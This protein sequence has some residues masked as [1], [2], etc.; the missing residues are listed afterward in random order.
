MARFWLACPPEE[1]GR[2]ARTPHTPKAPDVN[3]RTIP[4][5]HRTLPCRRMFLRPG[6]A[7]VT[8]A[9]C[10]LSGTAWASAPETDSALS[11]SASIDPAEQLAQASPGVVPRQ[12]PAAVEEEDEAPPAAQPARTAPRER[13]GPRVLS[14]ED[15]APDV[16]EIPGNFVEPFDAASPPRGV[17]VNIDFNQAELSDVVMWI[18]A[19]T[20]R[21]FI[22]ADTISSQKR[23]TI[24][25]PTP[26]TIQE[27]YR[28]FIAAL[29]MN[30]LTVVP[31]GRFQKIVESSGAQREP[32]IPS[33]DPADIVDDDRMV[34]HIHQL[35]HVGISTVQPVLDALK[36]SAGEIVAYEPTNTMIITETGRNLRRLL[37]I[38]QRLDVPSGQERIYMYQVQFAEADAL[39]GVLLEIFQRDQ[40]QQAQQAQQRQTTARAR[41]T[42]QAR[43]EPEPGPEIADG[44]A[45]VSVSQI[46][47]DERTNQLIIIANERSYERI[48][49]IARQLDV[50][51]ANEGQ[52]HVV[53][54]ENANATELANTLQSLVQGVQQ[55]RDDQARSPAAARR[56]AQQAQQAQSTGSGASFAGNL[57]ITADESTNSLVV[58][59][60][61]RDMIALRGVIEQ[62]DRRRQQVYVEAV[63]MEISLNRQNQFGLA[64]NAG[65]LP[66][67]GG[68]NV[69]VFGATSVGPLSSIILDPSSLTG[70]AVGARGPTVEG[71][72]GLLGPGIGLPS[73]GAI[74]QAIQTD[75]DVNVL[76]SPHLLTMD[77]EE[78]EIVVGENIPFISGISGVGGGG[79][80]GG[81]GGLAG[82]AGDLDLGGLA[83]SL[84]GLGG[85]GFPSVSV[86]RQD[87]AL[88]LRIRPQI[89]E[90]SFVRLEVEKQVDDVQSIDP[91]LGPR[92]T[93][94]QAR[95]VIVV[96]DQQTAVIGGL[97]RDSVIRDVSKVP[98]LGDI[99]VIGHFFRHSSTRTVKTNL[100]LLLTPYIIRD[101][102]DFAEIYR[103][104]M[105][106]REE[107]VAY[108]GRRDINYVR[109]VDYNRK[110]G[111]THRIG[112]RI[113][114]ALEREEER[115]RVFGTP[116]SEVEIG[117]PQNE[118]VRVP[119]LEDGPGL[120]AEGLDTS[121]E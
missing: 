41:R 120:P 36:T 55:Q 111:P 109:A 72:E 112:T 45:S 115:S 66:S 82:L 59:A 58:V 119:V 64:L 101:T 121:G 53:F 85:F 89:N 87:V 98:F 4:T 35:Q 103:R 10:S 30:G 40:Q 21:N 65:A 76:S 42:A 1:P 31:F 22:I 6:A 114:N 100:V 14:V 81:L 116:A 38:L 67:V 24:I 69:P 118:P 71:T 54:L 50:P 90:S 43:Q 20:G 70:L 15:V 11:S 102:A 75:N 113:R 91:I 56:T 8:L 60:T 62:L 7:L 3:E 86:Q 12:R 46:I 34:T 26:V 96:E 37:G 28:A 99:P 2:A 57:S 52:I 77:N 17:R 13:T 9:L 80:L 94:R 47:S 44:P 61:N 106:E 84:G 63:I 18:S 95:T 5:P 107:F 110:V 23:I 51:I 93:T 73:F 83:G 104:K 32:I 29:N 39:R 33:D 16:G 97:M 78:A 88:T 105:Q 74:M 25:S 68:E 79:G 49:E 48:L 19:L 92:T 108:F 27:A 117:R